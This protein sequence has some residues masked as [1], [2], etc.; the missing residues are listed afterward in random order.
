M[1]PPFKVGDQVIWADN[2]INRK[3][4]PYKIGE[5]ATVIATRKLDISDSWK[6]ERID[7]AIFV[8][9]C[10]GVTYDLY[11]IRFKIDNQALQPWNL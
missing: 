7:Y 4:Y 6:G 11:S 9:D 8:T 2:S 10:S 1:A 5:V 3:D